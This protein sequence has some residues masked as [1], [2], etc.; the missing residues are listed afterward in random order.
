MGFK[1]AWL[2][3]EEI[4]HALWKCPYFRERRALG[5]QVLQFWSRHVSAMYQVKVVFRNAERLYWIKMSKSAEEEYRFLQAAYER[6]EDVPELN[7]VKPV[8]YLEDIGALITE[9]TSGERLSSRI[10]RRLNRVSAVFGEDEGIKWSCYM[11]GKWLAVLHSH[12]L[13]AGHRYSPEELLEY[14]K[15]RLNLL[16][17]RSAFDRR[18]CD[19]VMAYLLKI[20]PMISLSDLERVKTHGDYAPYNIIV[21]GQELVVFD[22]SVGSYFG[23][24]GNYCARYEDIVHFYNH[25]KEL[26]PHIVSARTRSTLVGCFLQGYNENSRSPVDRSSPGFRAFLL[27]Y[28]LLGVLNTW[29][30]M[31]KWL[32]GENGRA[33]VFEWWFE[34]NC[35]HS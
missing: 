16:V 19:R 3:C 15:V 24:L 23:R 8:T 1:P 4:T 11:C 33:K 34:R 6:F 26:S 14:I 29:P 32:L 25:V 22:P 28:K 17:E 13:P 5:M 10:K 35:F 7:V 20:L 31:S 2:A 30:S 9:H 21:S 27:K 12:V 18:L